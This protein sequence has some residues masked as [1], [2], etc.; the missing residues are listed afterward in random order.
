MG[1]G[2]EKIEELV[3]NVSSDLG[4]MDNFRR[5]ALT[6][7]LAAANGLESRAEILAFTISHAELLVRVTSGT[8]MSLVLRLSGC[9]RIEAAVRW[10]GVRL[11]FEDLPN[12]ADSG[13]YVLFDKE[14]GFRVLCSLVLI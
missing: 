11:I 7:A 14:A 10:R 8:A 13:R 2:V 12:S 4:P 1:E 9:T 5:A 6:A 3:M